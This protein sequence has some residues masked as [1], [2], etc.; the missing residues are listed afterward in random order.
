M[1]RF[2]LLNDASGLLMDAYLRKLQNEIAVALRSLDGATPT[3][4][5][6]GKWTAAEVLE[7]L[8]LSYSGTVKGLNRCLREG[9]PLARKPSLQDRLKVTLVVRVGY[10]PHGRKA[11]DVSVPHGAPLEQVKV[12]VMSN[13][14]AMEKALAECEAKFG[15]NALLMDHP[16]L[17]PLTTQQWRKLHWVHGR[18]HVKQILQLRQKEP[19]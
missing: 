8:S 12:E 3:Q 16:I 19:Q 9:K 18:H 6:Q 4:T 7:H 5:R 2:I 15:K 13:L 11:P 10:M 17:G 14:A 1:S